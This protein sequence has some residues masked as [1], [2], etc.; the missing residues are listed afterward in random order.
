M[1]KI[2]DGAFPET[3]GA[4]AKSFNARSRTNPR[5]DSYN[6]RIFRSYFRNSASGLD[7]EKS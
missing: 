2:K 1:G 3:D 7:S 5:P 4:N 6:L